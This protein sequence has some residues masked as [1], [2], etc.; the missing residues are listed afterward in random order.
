MAFLI[1]WLWCLVA[2]LA[3]SGVA[4]LIGALWRRR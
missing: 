2:F 3:G 1:Q 4:Y